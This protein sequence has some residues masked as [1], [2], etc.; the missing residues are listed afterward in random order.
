MKIERFSGEELEELLGEGIRGQVFRN[1][2]TGEVTIWSP[3]GATTHELLHEVGHARQDVQVGRFKGGTRSTAF[4]RRAEEEV[5]AELYSYETMGKKVSWKIGLQPIIHLID[6]GAEPVSACYTTFSVLEGRSIK[7]SRSD[8]DKLLRWAQGE[9][10]IS[11]I[12]EE[13]D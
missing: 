10:P 7:L 3:K 1:K 8:K 5:D 4:R 13:E 9:W 6:L 2:V 12:E 11:S